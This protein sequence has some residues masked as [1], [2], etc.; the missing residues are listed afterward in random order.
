MAH[1]LNLTAKIKKDAETAKKVEELRAIFP[2]VVQPMIDSALRKSR[3]VH[4][5]RV[6]LIPEK[7]PEYIQVI[8]EFDGDPKIYTEF[9]RVALPE[10]FKKIFELV[11][12]APPWG[13]LNTPDM[14]FKV[15]SGVHLA[16][17]GTSDTP[18][19]PNSLKQGYLFSAY[20]ATSVEDILKARKALSQIPA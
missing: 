9:F 2:T 16:S 10:V 19:G 12:D 6:L 1:A 5:A 7:E 8:T 4:F 11:E 14:F 15:A 20:G 3:M 17:L 13:E 18:A